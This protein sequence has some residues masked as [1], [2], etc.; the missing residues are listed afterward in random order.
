MLFQNTF[1]LLPLLKGHKVYR[2]CA[3]VK[4]LKHVSKM[5]MK[6]SFSWLCIQS[7]S[8]FRRRLLPVFHETFPLSWDQLSSSTWFSPPFSSNQ[9]IER[10]LSRTS[11]IVPANSACPEGG[12]PKGGEE[13]KPRRSAIRDW[14]MGSLL[15]ERRR[16]C[17]TWAPPAATNVALLRLELPRTILCHFNPFASKQRLHRLYLATLSE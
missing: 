9:L 8:R 7:R 2:S 6:T 3:A 17:S 15:L 13:S 16:R 1:L 11:S 14:W 10:C 4:N 12:Q 5:S